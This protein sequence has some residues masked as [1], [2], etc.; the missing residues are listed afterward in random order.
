MAGH[1]RDHLVEEI[2]QKLG[3]LLVREAG[4]PHLQAVTI[5]G[6]KLAK[7]LS[8]AQVLF[9]S[10]LEGA[11]PED[12]SQRLNNAAGFLSKALGRTLSSR[13]MPRL[14]FHYD[15]GFDY[16]QDMERLF[17]EIRKDDE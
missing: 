2:R 15:Q 4:D 17:K 16:A 11:D 9:S 5:T 10:Y 6:V 8:T 12:L 13:K 1:K 3:M 14:H 7:D